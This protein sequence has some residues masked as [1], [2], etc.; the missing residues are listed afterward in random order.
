[1]EQWQAFGVTLA[2]EMPTMLLLARRHAP[3]RVA[4]GAISINALTHPAAWAAAMLLA[5]AQYR[6]GLWVIEGIVAV[7]EAAWYRWWLGV[8]GLRALGWA[9][10]AN[11]ASLGLGWWLW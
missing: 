1:M 4:Q 8:G 7:L 5:P 2:C 11:A 9:L 10:L 3:A 6:V